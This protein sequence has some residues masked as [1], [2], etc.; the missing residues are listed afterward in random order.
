MGRHVWGGKAERRAGL[1]GTSKRILHCFWFVHV[2]AVPILAV[3]VFAFSSVGLNVLFLSN[4]GALR[5]RS[6]RKISDIRFRW[7]RGKLH[8]SFFVISSSSSVG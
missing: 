8:F 4:W 6:V 3:V 7:P 1:L 5:L 2:F